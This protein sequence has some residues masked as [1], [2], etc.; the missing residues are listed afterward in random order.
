M[1][2]KNCLS[3]GS[4]GGRLSDGRECATKCAVKHHYKN[5]IVGNHML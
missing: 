4:N 3:G 2:N 1:T 5:T